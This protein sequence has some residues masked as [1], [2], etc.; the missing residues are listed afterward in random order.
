M[1]Q[2]QKPIRSPLVVRTPSPLPPGKARLIRQSPGLPWS[3]IEVATS[4]GRIAVR[5]GHGQGVPLLLLHGNS[6]DRDVFAPL[7]SGPSG[8]S[9]RMI[10]LDLPG[11]GASSD[12]V[13]PGRTY[14]IPGY[15]DA[16]IEVLEHLDLTR[17]AILGWSLGGH[18][19]LD[20]AARY[21]GVLGVLLCGTPPVGTSPEAILAGFTQHP[22][23]PLVGQATLTPAEI[24]AFA[25]MTV[26]S[27]DRTS[28]AA[29][30]ARTDGR[31]RTHMFAHL[32][33]G[34]VADQRTFVEG[35][36]MPVALV[37]GDDDPLV[38]VTYVRNFRAASL[39]YGRPHLIREGGHAP[40]LSQPKSFRRLLGRFI[41]S[42]SRRA[43]RD[44]TNPDLCFSG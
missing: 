28:A 8:E 43:L 22:D 13:D 44:A 40:F 1:P 21:P 38:D 33:G 35:T 3:D 18:V 39:W 17:V 11:H 26:G 9:C 37:C 30:I 5:L 25:R 27:A 36:T 7:M 14:S 10:A 24:D 2:L 12:A 16:V 34:G 4:H 20:V 15:A 32:L 6:A 42:M 23:L 31:A 41:R 29:A 19:A